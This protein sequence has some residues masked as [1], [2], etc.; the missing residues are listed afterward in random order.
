MDSFLTFPAFVPLATSGIPVSSSILCAIPVIGAQVVPT[1]ASGGQIAAVIAAQ[2]KRQA[3]RLA[4]Y[5]IGIGSQRRYYARIGP[6]CQQV[7]KDAQGCDLAAADV[8]VHPHG[9]GAN[10]VS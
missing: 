1:S 7:P 5:H 2:K 3:R 4:H 9:R 10:G 8:A 6:V